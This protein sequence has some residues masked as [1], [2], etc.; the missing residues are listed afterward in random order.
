MIW[1]ACHLE[2]SEASSRLC[3]ALRKSSGLLTL[4]IEDS[5]ISCSHIGHTCMFVRMSQTP[6]RGR[7]HLASCRHQFILYLPFSSTASNPSNTSLNSLHTHKHTHSH[8]FGLNERFE[9]GVEGRKLTRRT[10][11]PVCHD[12][13]Q[14]CQCEAPC[15]RER[16][17]LTKGG[18]AKAAY[19][20]RVPPLLATCG[21][22]Q[23]AATQISLRTHDTQNT[24]TLMRYKYAQCPLLSELSERVKEQKTRMGGKENTAH[25]S[26][27]WQQ[28]GAA[29]MTS[30]R[31][32]VA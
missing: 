5:T 17:K 27:V 11:T 28:H 18:N 6:V 26:R 23:R 25:E 12:H 16:S 10:L 8:L 14:T 20:A 24:N 31:E 4:V 29:C 7:A 19:C 21:Q 15:E 3:A 30:S 13:L 22:T 9:F 1:L 2:S 32:H